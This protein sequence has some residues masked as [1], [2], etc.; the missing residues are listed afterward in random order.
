MTHYNAGASHPPRD[1]PA[2][3]LR[4]STLPLYRQLQHSLRDLIESGRWAP[5]SQVPPERDLMRMFGVSRTTVRE[6]LQGLEEEG[7]IVRRHGQ[8]TFVARPRAARPLA[9]LRGFAEE[10]QEQGFD[11]RVRVL[12]YGMVRLPDEAAEALGV[13]AGSPGAEISRVVAA[14]GRPLFTDVSY[15]LETAGRRVLAA[16]P[17]SSIYSALEAVGLPVVSGE[18]TI[19]ATLAGPAEAELLEMRAGEPLLVVRRIARLADGTPV[20][21]RRVAY[22]ADRYRYRVFLTR[23]GRE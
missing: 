14:D 12:R 11:V 17:A 10:L 16:E 22:R 5:G 7:L 20:E 8:G 4:G 6:A 18:Q 2:G 15:L 9:R 23:G 21:F 19:E 1:A 13:P 3:V